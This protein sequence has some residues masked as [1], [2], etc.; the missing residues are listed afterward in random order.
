MKYN[1]KVP[2]NLN[3]LTVGQYL[4]YI[5]IENPTKEDLLT[6]FLGL[7][8]KTL[9]SLKADSVNKL[10]N[11][12]NEILSEK[13]SFYPTFK[14]EG[15][16]Y[17]FEPNL[18]DITF[19]VNEDATE[20]LKEPEKLNKALAVLYRPITGRIGSKYRI[21]EYKGSG[22][23]SELFLNAPLGIALGMSVFFC[24]LTTD[25]LKATL[26]STQEEMMEEVL[27]LE[28]DKDS[29]RSGGLTKNSILLLKEILEDLKKSG[30][31][32]FTNV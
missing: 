19:G 23:R 30:D 4:N 11:Q 16:S 3:E 29:L 17:G 15:V 26:N 22:S 24:N 18:D 21:E 20:Y 14:L 6:S 32:M 2:K 9:R 13:P 8:L 12:L 31:L 10:E 25:L 5:S 1:L 7:D 27:L 28:R